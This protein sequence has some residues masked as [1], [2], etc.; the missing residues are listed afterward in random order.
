MGSTAPGRDAGADGRAGA[1]ARGGSTGSSPERVG[2]RRFAGG[3]AAGPV[4]GGS[5]GSA[6]P[7]PLDNRRR[8][9]G[10]R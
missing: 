6:P 10:C 4:R 1:D 3:E 2:A 5:G 7:P 8:L 9:W